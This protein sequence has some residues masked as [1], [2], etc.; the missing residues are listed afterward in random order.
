MRFKLLIIFL[1][2]NSIVS[3]QNIYSFTLKNIVG[4]E[5]HISNYKGKVLLIVNTASECGFTPQ[6]KELE[7][8]YQLYKDK[9]FEILA[10]PSN[11][12]GKQEPLNGK[13][14][15][16][17]CTLNYKTTFQ[18][19]DKVHVKG[20]D[21][22]P[23]YQFLSSKKLNGNLSSTPKWNFHKYL[24]N[25]NGEVVDYFYSTTKPTSAKIKKSIEKLLGG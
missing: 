2:M 10:F 9:G 11:D 20:N 16:N 22:A 8:L 18:V 23:F 25:R 24:V 4:E 1:I 3:A 6:F 19:F 15:Q 14:I 21:A 5:T 12:F 13:E 7:E 17:F